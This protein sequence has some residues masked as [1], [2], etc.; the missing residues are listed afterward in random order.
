[1][2]SRAPCTRK[3]ARRHGLTVAVGASRIEPMGSRAILALVAVLALGT[4]GWLVGVGRGRAS[5]GVVGERAG[6]GREAADVAATPGGLEDPVVPAQPS[7]EPGSEREEVEAGAAKSGPAWHVLTVQARESGEPLA[8]VHV[9]VM[10]EFADEGTLGE[11]RWTSLSFAASGAK[12]VRCPCP[13]TD[14]HGRVEIETPP[15]LGRHLLV[16][17]LENVHARQETLALP[18]LAAG[19]RRELTITLE[20]R[21]DL[22]WFG[23]VLDDA[24]GTP[25]AGVSAEWTSGGPLGARGTDVSSA[26]GLL[27]LEFASWQTTELSVD[28]P[29]Y[30]A[31]RVALERGHDNAESAYPLRLVRPAV[32]E[33]RVRDPLG[34][35]LSGIGVEVVAV[36]P[37]GEKVT[38]LSGST[39]QPLVRKELTQHDGIARVADLPPRQELMA[40][41]RPGIGRTQRQNVTLAP[42]EARALDFVVG[43]G[44]RLQGVA[45]DEHGEPLASLDVWRLAVT[46]VPANLEPEHERSVV[47]KARTDARGRFVFE[48]VPP[49]DWWLGPAPYHRR[50]GI[51]PLATRVTI[52]EDESARALTLVCHSARY[53]RGQVLSA[54]GQPVQATVTAFQAG[55]SLSAESDAAGSFQVGPLAGGEWLLQARVPRSME[56]PSE[57]VRVEAG[58]SDVR[59]QLRAGAIVSGI[60]LDERG[61][62]VPEAEVGL[63][64]DGSAF[65]QTAFADDEGRFTFG[66]QAPGSYALRATSGAAAG[67]LGP[68]RVEAGRD[69]GPL[70]L[71]LAL[72]AEL[73]L[74]LAS[75][76]PEDLEVWLSVDRVPLLV[77]GLAPGA[78]R[79]ERLAPGT[80]RV[81]LVRRT[82][83]APPQVLEEQ[84]LELRAGATAQLELGAAAR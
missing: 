37:E 44:C 75:G 27:V 8:D 15:G 50:S 41:V 58:R 20:T 63:A 18:A 53:V 49:G 74:H 67:R 71:P 7:V 10:N 22:R 61:A 6:E 32:L 52:A 3:V 80:A 33:V 9:L 81:Q 78:E 38:W 12:S 30:L 76:A 1:M 73:V 11:A 31:M 57:L 54:G 24:T 28:V 19:E 25:L 62:P 42:G 77:T 48:N 56:G 45:V 2:E 70:E 51:V 82:L 72:G 79:R 16:N 35:P 65:G 84:S 68:F 21:D 34:A 36:E 47:D 26:D 29:G 66:A 43:S 59:L 39:R 69:L 64:E 46:N 83:G 55:Q 60:V 4:A 23:R 14:A 13:S 40:V 17:V 5:R